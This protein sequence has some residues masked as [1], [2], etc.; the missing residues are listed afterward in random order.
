MFLRLANGR[1]ALDIGDF[2][3]PPPT[4]PPFTLRGK[5]WHSNTQDKHRLK[6]TN[7]HL[8]CLE[9]K[10]GSGSPSERRF[11]RQAQRFQLSKSALDLFSSERDG[12]NLFKFSTPNPLGE[13]NS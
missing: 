8:H 7:A 5:H 6:L 12:D 10:V 1:E 4:P 13:R 3:S 2:S 9:K 11:R